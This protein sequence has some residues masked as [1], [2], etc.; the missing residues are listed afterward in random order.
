MQQT[1]AFF[2]LFFFFFSCCINVYCRIKITSVFILIPENLKWK[3]HSFDINDYQTGLPIDSL[4][5][6]ILEY[7]YI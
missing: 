5:I 1:F 3:K 6:I 7:S 2:L 4:A